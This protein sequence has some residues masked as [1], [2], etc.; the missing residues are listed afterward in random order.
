MQRFQVNTHH[1]NIFYG[2]IIDFGLA[3]MQESIYKSIQKEIPIR[4]SAPEVLLGEKCSEFSDMWSFGVTV[5]EIFEFAKKPYGDLGTNEQVKNF[6][7]KGGRLSKP[8]N[9]PEEIWKVVED[10]WK[11]ENNKTSNRPTFQI[12]CERLLSIVNPQVEE[13]FE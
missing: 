5:W 13:E 9:C 8:N 11:W 3:V 12:M 1:L 6:I 2:Y 10:C 7:F 4:W